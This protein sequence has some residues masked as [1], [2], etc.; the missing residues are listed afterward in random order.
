MSFELIIRAL[1]AALKF[2]GEV[3]AIID[4]LDY[5]PEEKRLKLK[6]QILKE[7]EEFARTG[8]PPQ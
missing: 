7:K 1:I 3:F 6:E 5:A 8:R 4:F 2:P